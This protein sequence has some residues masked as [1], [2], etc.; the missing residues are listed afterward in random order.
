MGINFEETFFVTGFFCLAMKHFC[1]VIIFITILI[2][3][4]KKNVYL[5]REKPITS[6]TSPFLTSPGRL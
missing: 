5:R 6:F 2:A 4:N 1:R 3:G